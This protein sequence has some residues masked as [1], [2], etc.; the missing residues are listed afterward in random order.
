M[1]TMDQPLFGES[2][3]QVSWLRIV[4]KALLNAFLFGLVS[5]N[6]CDSLLNTDVDDNRKNAEAV[7]ILA[8]LVVSVATSL[9]ASSPQC[10]LFY[11]RM[12]LRGLELIPLVYLGS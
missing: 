6:S 12:C 8:V 9:F 5:G 11:L 1:R 4:L 7:C 10:R 2:R 3:P